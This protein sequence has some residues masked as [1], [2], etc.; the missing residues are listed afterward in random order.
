MPST[1]TPSPSTAPPGS[2]CT[3]PK[4]ET[5][6]LAFAHLDMNASAPTKVALE[7]VWS[8]LVPGGMVVFDDYG[9]A[10]YSDQKELIDAF[11]A[12]KRDGL[13]ALPTGQALS[14]KL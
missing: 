12:D 10:Q 4:T 9:W 11:Y 1:A 6:P 3:L 7:Y 14:V 13:I 8:R 5:G 2:T